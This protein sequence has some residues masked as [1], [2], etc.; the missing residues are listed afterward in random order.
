MPMRPKCLG[1]QKVTMQPCSGIRD[2]SFLI[3]KKDLNMTRGPCDR[4]LGLTGVCE[5]LADVYKPFLIFY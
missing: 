2:L 1:S 5:I 4:I 3:C